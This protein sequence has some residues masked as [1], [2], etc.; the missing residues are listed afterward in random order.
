VLP[1][2][3][4]PAPPVAPLPLPALAAS[5]TMIARIRSDTVDVPFQQSWRSFFTGMSA[6]GRG[7]VAAAQRSMLEAIAVTQAISIT[8][9]AAERERRLAQ[10]LSNK[11]IADRLTMSSRS[12]EGHLF[13]ASHRVG[14]NSRDQLISI[15]EGADR[16]P[17]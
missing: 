15:L 7:D 8:R 1:G 12:V 16:Q 14:A 2:A 17:G 4:V 10:G 11:E 5:D 6:V 9:E 13:R 3:P